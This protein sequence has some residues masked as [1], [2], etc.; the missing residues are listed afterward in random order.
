MKDKLSILIMEGPDDKIAFELY[1]DGPKALEA[2]SNLAGKDGD[3]KSRA[4]FLHLDQTNGEIIHHEVKEL[5]IIKD[6]KD[7]PWGHELGVG[8][9]EKPKEIEKDNGNAED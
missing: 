5:P 4:T 2:F 9:I 1:K 7:E 3:P 8:P 6:P